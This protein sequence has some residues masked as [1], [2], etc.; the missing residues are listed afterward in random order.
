MSNIDG[1]DMTAVDGS[2]E[3]LQ[4]QS[5]LLVLTLEVENFSM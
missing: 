2:S 1:L 3:A 5:K 4:T